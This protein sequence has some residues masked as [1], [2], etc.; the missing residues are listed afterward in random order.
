MI[1]DRIHI[2]LYKGEE[3]YRRVVV[4]INLGMCVFC[5]VLAYAIEI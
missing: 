4:E 1:L 2:S 5:G 3:N